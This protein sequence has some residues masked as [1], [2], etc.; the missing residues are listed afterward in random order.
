MQAFLLI[1]ISLFIFRKYRIIIKIVLI[2]PIINDQILKKKSPSITVLF[3]TCSFRI[4]DESIHI[5]VR[6]I[7]CIVQK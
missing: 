5:A 1:N 3:I 6:H 4:N 2:P 7:I